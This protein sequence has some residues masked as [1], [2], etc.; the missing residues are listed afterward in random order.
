MDGERYQKSWKF[1]T[2]RF[3]DTLYRI[4][5]QTTQI[6]VKPGSTLILYFV[7]NS[8]HDVLNGFSTTHGLKVSFIDNNTLKVNITQA[9][10]GTASIKAGGRT[11]LF[12]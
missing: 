11:I 1:T 2:K 8:P 4:T 12:K 5:K 7:P 3:N 9:V 10:V 6:D